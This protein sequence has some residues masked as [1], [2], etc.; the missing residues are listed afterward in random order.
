MIEVRQEVHSAIAPSA[1]PLPWLLRMLRRLP[2]PRKLGLLERL[3]GNS[4]KRFGICWVETAE[5]PVWKLNLD[6]PCDRWM[7]F[8]DYE[9]AVQMN[10][11]RG[12]LKDGGNVIDSGTN[13]GQMLMYFS[14]SSNVTVLGFEP[15][16]EVYEWV[17]SC[18]ERNALTNVSV[19]SVGLGDSTCSATLRLNG[20]RSTMRAD[21]YLDSDLK[22]VQIDV[23]A[24][25]DVLSDR[26]ITRV[27][28]WKL[29]VEGLELVALRG[30]RRSLLQGRID[31]VL[32]EVNVERFEE[33]R[34]FFAEVGYAIYA[35]SRAGLR[36][37]SSAAGHGNLIALPKSAAN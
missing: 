33:L 6:D 10:W 4:I 34:D 14:R 29:D 24:L 25:D 26:G 12:W 17:S 7:V 19:I 30:A 31:A 27:R 20:P 22:E 36:P 37:V 15:H 13:I 2:M 35:N 8:G 3:F 18:I 11:I 5:G 23:R 21:W 16:P 32:F 28:L 9:G 1:V